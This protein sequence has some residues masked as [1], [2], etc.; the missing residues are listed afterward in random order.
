MSPELAQRRSQRRSRSRVAVFAFIGALTCLLGPAPGRAGSREA[1]ELAAGQATEAHAARFLATG[2]AA[3][4]AGDLPAANAALVESYRLA[5]NPEVL[6]RL[7]MLALAEHRALPARDLLLRFLADPGPE[8]STDSALVKEA[9]RL[10]QPPGPPAAELSVLGERNSLVYVDERLVGALPLPRP[11]LLSPEEH[12]VALLREGRHLQGQLRV[13]EG[14]LGEL[15]FDHATG[16]VLFA[17]LPGVVVLERYDDAAAEDGRALSAAVT[18]AVQRE[19]LSPLQ[20]AS[21]AA[22]PAPQ[23][24]C[25]EDA[26]CQVKLGSNVG[27]DY[28]LS[29]RVR[30][31][32]AGWQVLLSLLSIE[33]GAVAA[34]RDSPCPGCTTA[35]V[36]QLITDSFASL[37]GEAQSRPRGTLAVRTLR[38]GEGA[39]V[40]LDGL[41]VGVTPYTHATWAGRHQLEVRAQGYQVERRDLELGDG[42]TQTVEVQLQARPP[43][44]A[45]LSTPGRQPRPRW[46]WIA[47]ATAL[48]AGALFVGFG[49][50]ALAANG[51]CADTPSV[52]GAECVYLYRSLPIGAA[53]TSVGGVLLLGGIGLLA[54]PGKRSR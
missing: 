40:W 42:A 50:S 41:K 48:G 49:A 22:P 24:S 34:Q 13:P 32:A 12:R 10:V 36:G 18:L 26:S 43:E 27:A 4:Q 29:L 37:W 9:E 54:V 31:E 19:R 39:E 8:V 46:R 21:Q 11:L 7:G 23:P 15:R 33:V 38:A 3:L 1:S 44:R 6:F 17:V 25:Q 35:Q 53:L 2:T 5:H 47:G 14:R 52:P 28:V 20:S 45:P 51:T 30:K 16:A